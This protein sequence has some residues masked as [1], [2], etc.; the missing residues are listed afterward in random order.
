[1]KDFALCPDCISNEEFDLSL[2]SCKGEHA[3]SCLLCLCN[4]CG[5]GS[6]KD[7]ALLYEVLEWCSLDNKDPKRKEEP[8]AKH[9]CY[10]S[11]GHELAAKVLDR[12]GLIE[13]GSGIGWPW[14]TEK[15]KQ[16]L[17]YITTQENYETNKSK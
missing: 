14:I 17:E 13:H 6:S 2:C 9:G 7:T 10:C 11:P 12:A 1:M 4:L 16:V 15:G 8:F 5:C 3:A